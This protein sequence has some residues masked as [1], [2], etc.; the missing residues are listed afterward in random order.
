MAFVL[1]L[2]FDWTVN[3]FVD[4]ARMDDQSV[5]SSWPHTSYPVVVLIIST[6]VEQVCLNYGKPDQQPI[7]R[8]TLADARRYAEEGHF[9]AGSMSPKIQAVVEFLEAGG[10]QALITN[11]PNLARA[12]NGET[13]TW[14]V[15]E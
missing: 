10:H 8:M 11:P 12:I 13:G 1:V 9:G 6:A 14:I 2:V 5:P 15:P 7:D 4:G 3:P